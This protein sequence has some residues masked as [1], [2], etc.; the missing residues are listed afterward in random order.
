M[1]PSGL[2][3]DLA[4]V[5]AGPGAEPGTAAH[6]LHRDARSSSTD[7]LLVRIDRTAPAAADG[8][9]PTLLDADHLEPLD[10]IVGAVDRRYRCVVVSDGPDELVVE[11]VLGD[12]ELPVPDDVRL[13]EFSTG[14]DFTITDRGTPVV[15]RTGPRDA[16]PG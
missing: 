11:V 12:D 10:A 5:A 7:R 14:A 16:G 2:G 6:L 4:D 15:L 8:A 3:A 9:W 1:P 13:T